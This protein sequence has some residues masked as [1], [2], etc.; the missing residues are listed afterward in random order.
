[1]MTAPRQLPSDERDRLRPVNGGFD[2][3]EIGDVS[4]RVPVAG[5]VLIPVAAAPASTITDINT[6]PVVLR[7]RRSVRQHEQNAAASYDVPRELTTQ[8]RFPQ[9][10]GCRLS[11]Q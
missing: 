6:A 5:E 9:Y 8:L 11:G 10:P 4:V 3:L 2:R 7:R 1:M